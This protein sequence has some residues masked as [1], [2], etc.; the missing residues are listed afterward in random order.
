MIAVMCL[1]IAAILYPLASD[2]YEKYRQ[3]EVITNYQAAQKKTDAA[4]QKAAKAQA[5]DYNQRIAQ[6][7]KPT[8]K[9]PF[10]TDAQ[11]DTN[12][13]YDLYQSLLGNTLG[14][15]RIPKIDVNLPIYF[16]TN[17]EQ[18]EKG[19]GVIPGTSLPTGGSSTH[20]VI[21][22]HRGLKKA[23]LFTDLPELA[24]GDQFFVDENQQTL[25]Y[26]V[27]QIK[28]VLPTETD[29]LKVTDGQD[30]VTLL[31]CTPLGVNTHRLLVRGHRVPYEKQAEKVALADQA[32][33]ATRTY[34]P[35][36]IAVGAVLGLVIISWW[37]KRQK[38]KR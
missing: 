4:A 28:T 30:Y 34:Q 11:P 16:G 15:V 18:L 8:I 22:A 24:I 27:D 32:K 1:G 21:T 9:D 6:R 35:V 33:Q 2:L 37:L 7:T 17:D 36:L 26:E 5:A 19:A 14:V 29:Y 23:R 10:A 20:S 25:A 3:H 31:T 13:S 38:E 12:G